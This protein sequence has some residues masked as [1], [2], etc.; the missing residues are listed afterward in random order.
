MIKT[1]QVCDICGREVSEKDF[2]SVK[3]KSQ[4]FVNYAN[5]DIIGANR[6]RFDICRNCVEH[7]IDYVRTRK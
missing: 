1:V 5:Y 4:A 6:Q 7:F 2:Y 3:V